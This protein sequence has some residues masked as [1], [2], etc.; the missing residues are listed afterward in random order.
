MSE[1][2]ADLRKIP[3]HPAMRLLA[4]ANSRLQTPLRSPASAPVEAILDELAEAGAFVDMLR[5]MSVALPGRE[6]AWWACL[7][8]RDILGPDADPL[9]RT[10]AAAEAWVFRPGD[11]TRA[12]VRQ[13]AETA[14]ADDDMVLC[15]TAAVMAEGTL[16]PGA[17]AEF[18]APPGGAEA[19]AF[20]MNVMALEH[21]G[22]PI[23]QAADFLIDRAA[24][25]ARGGNGKL[26]RP[27]PAAAPVARPAAAGG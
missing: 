18:P 25:I 6:R 13:A 1:R 15:A 4:A 14:D 16:G 26:P 9:P 21:L 23:A 7:A 3:A 19:A 20:G 2:F 24:D 17:L 22:L 10:L 11:D 8:A 12:A 5:L 27:A